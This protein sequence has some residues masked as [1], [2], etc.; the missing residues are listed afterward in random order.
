MN[1]EYYPPQGMGEHMPQYP[2]SSDELYAAQINEDKIKNIISQISPSNQVEDIEM[3]IRGYKKNFETGEW[4]LIHKRNET[5]S[6]L[7][8]SRYVAF[9]G[10]IMNLNT[11]LGNLSPAQVTSIMKQ[12]IQWVVDDIDNHAEE[13]GIGQDFSERTRVCDIIL[14]ST[15]FCLNRSLNGIEARRFWSSLSLSESS[16]MNPNNNPKSEWWKFWKK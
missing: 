16:S 8:I 4:E 9:L 2:V 12:T 5:I 15:F 14:N 13:Y 6:D 3:R 10:S 11:T 7:L 1:E